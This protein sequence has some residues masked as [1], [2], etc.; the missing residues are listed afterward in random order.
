[1]GVK[2]QIVRVCEPQKMNRSED[3]NYFHY[4]VLQIKTCKNVIFYQ[5]KEKLLLSI[6]TDSYLTD[7]GMPIYLINNNS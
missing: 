1:M 5:L 3:K 7:K 2:E 6:K 4:S